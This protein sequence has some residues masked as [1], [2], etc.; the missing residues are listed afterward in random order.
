[1]MSSP[2]RTVEEIPAQPR[3]AGALI[4]APDGVLF[5]GDSKSVQSS[6]IPT[7]ALR[8]R[9]ELSSR[10]CSRTSIAASQRPSKSMS[11]P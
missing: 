6:P 1:M 10:S 7:S 3:S 11:V 5:V 8:R 2:T 9:R 4:F